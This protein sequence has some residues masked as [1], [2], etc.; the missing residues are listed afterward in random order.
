MIVI[1]RIL[2]ETD[3]LGDPLKTPVTRGM[4]SLAR[5][6]ASLTFA[7]GPLSHFSV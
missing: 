7:R 1:W 2:V 4:K 6:V 3:I 5:Q